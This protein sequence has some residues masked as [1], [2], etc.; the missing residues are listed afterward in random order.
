VA[1][2]RLLAPA[3]ACALVASAVGTPAHGG[4]PLRRPLRP[5]AFSDGL[6]PVRGPAEAR[7]TVAVMAAPGGR[8]RIPGET[9]TMG[10]DVRDLE[11]ARAL[12]EKE[13]S[14]VLCER[15]TSADSDQGLLRETPAHMVTV[16]P[17]EL[18]RFEV[19]VEAYGRCVSAGACAAPGFPAGDARFD[20]PELP[21][22]H[23]SWDDASTFC[24]WARGRLPTE[25]E[26]ELAARGPTGRDFP[27]G[28]SWDG[29]LCNHGSLS[30][31]ETDGSDS[32]LYLAPVG[33]YPGGATL[34]GVHD[35]AGN[36][37]EWVFDRF[38]AVAFMNTAA[39][40]AARAVTNPRVATGARA[41]VLGGSWSTGAPW[42][43]GAS[44]WFRAPH[45]RTPDTG[46]R[47]AY[48]S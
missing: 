4:D 37:S 16:S 5:S 47:C 2:T 45:V 10:S 9:F 29:R 48:D 42:A 11:R 34:L 8:V 23:V 25:A 39:G 6:A 20:R 35:L 7:G 3:L 1:H 38:D 33:S 43:R 14:R 46:F 21:V 15:I 41:I 12:C 32:F 27:W 31:D 17:F 40:Y 13:P 44:R 30:T 19:T 36:V 24:T 22:T 18:D 26:W 28:F